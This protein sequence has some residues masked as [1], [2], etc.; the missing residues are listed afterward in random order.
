M[1]K[2][3]Y[4]NTGDSE[5]AFRES[6]AYPAENFRGFSCI[7]ATSLGMYFLPMLSP[8]NSDQND[9]IDLTITTGK[10]QD[11]ITAIQKEISVGASNYVTIADD[12]N[13]RYLHRFITACSAPADSSDGSSLQVNKISGSTAVELIDISTRTRRIKSMSLANIHATD[14]AAVDLYI[15]NGSGTDYYIFKNLSI[16]AGATLQLDSDE[17]HYDFTTYNLYVKLGATGSTVD[18]TI[19]S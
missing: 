3:L 4:F 6:L 10:H 12:D 13:S 8:T 1:E 2:V 5:N 18:V 16:P 19:R 14:A 11:V 17:L 9:L 7:D 15:K